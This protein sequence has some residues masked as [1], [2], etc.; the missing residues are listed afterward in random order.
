MIIMRTIYILINTCGYKGC[1]LLLNTFNNK[2]D[3]RES[4]FI[5]LTPVFLAPEVIYIYISEFAALYYPQCSNTDSKLVNDFGRTYFE[6]SGP[7]D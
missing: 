4:P 2:F 6:M 3:M 7:D 5:T 1:Y